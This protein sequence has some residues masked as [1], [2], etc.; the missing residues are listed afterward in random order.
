[1]VNGYLLDTN[2][3]SYLVDESRAEHTSAI[4]RF[5][6]LPDDTPLFTSVITLGELEYGRYICGASPSRDAFFGGR[7]QT[8]DITRHTSYVYGCLR[9]R[10]FERFSPHE[11][12]TKRMR[13]WQLVDPVSEEKLG[14]QENDL[15]IAAQ[16]FEMNLVLVTHDRMRRICAICEAANN[17]AGTPDP[18]CFE[19]W[20]H[21]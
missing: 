21:D 6:E 10:L 4:R 13:P 8:L 11:Y 17:V 3:L 5:G 1:M 9:A 18:P 14:I 20:I 16:A 15:W 12:R 2:T 7:L 19:D